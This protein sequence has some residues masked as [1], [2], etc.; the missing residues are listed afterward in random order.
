MK[1]L[2]SLQIPVFAMSKLFETGRKHF[3]RFVERQSPHSSARI[4]SHEQAAVAC[5]K[6]E[7]PLFKYKLLAADF[8]HT[9]ALYIALSML[10]FIIMH[11]FESMYEAKSHLR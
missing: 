8:V 5:Y 7:W 9:F 10:R 11:L 3:P 1:D 6:Q 2:E 4:V